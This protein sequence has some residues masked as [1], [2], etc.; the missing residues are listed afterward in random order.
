MSVTGPMTRLIVTYQVSPYVNVLDTTG[1]RISHGQTIRSIKDPEM[2]A[3]VYHRL[4]AC[5]GFKLFKAAVAYGVVGQAGREKIGEI[6]QVKTVG[7]FTYDPD[8]NILTASATYDRK[9][10]RDFVVDYE[11]IR[12]S[13]TYCYSDDGAAQGYMTGDIRLVRPNKHRFGYELIYKLRQIDFTPRYATKS[14]SQQKA[15]AIPPI[16][17]APAPIPKP[18]SKPSA[19]PKSKRCLDNDVDAD[20]HHVKRSRTT[21]TL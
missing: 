14:S 8:K 10:G 1:T 20:D 19:A 5:T 17:P 18:K 12:N 2:Q 9:D 4:T 11:K 16:P 15:T 6:L 3:L 21:K 13:V 7:K